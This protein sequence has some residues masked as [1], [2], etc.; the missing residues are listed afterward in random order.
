M[1]KKTE[2]KGVARLGVDDQAKNEGLSL[3]NLLLICFLTWMDTSHALVSA[4]PTKSIMQQP[5]LE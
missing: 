5:R 1:K 3:A 4:P 2:E